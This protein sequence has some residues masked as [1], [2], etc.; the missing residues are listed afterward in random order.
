MYFNGKKKRKK[1]DTRE[2][3]P[4]RNPTGSDRIRP[5]PTGNKIKINIALNALLTQII[6]FYNQIFRNRI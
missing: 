5:D 2:L 6:Y 1:E 4:D 3:I